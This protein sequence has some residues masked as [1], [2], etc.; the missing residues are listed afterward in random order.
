MSTTF[1]IP[2]AFDNKGNVID[3]KDAV[4]NIDYFCQCGEIVR[5]R[6]GEIISDHFYHIKETECCNESIIHK[7]YKA[8]LLRDKKIKLPMPYNGVSLLEF[9]KV[10]LEKQI[11]DF[12]PDAIGWKDGTRYLI[13]F[14]KTNWIGER[15]LNKIKKS[16]LFCLEVSIINATT[17]EEISNHL[18][19]DGY[20][21]QIIHAPE[22]QEFEEFKNK[23][24]E[25][26]R[27]LRDDYE[28]KLKYY[29]QTDQI[30][31]H[32]QGLIVKF[33]TDCKNG[34]KLYCHN[35]LGLSV[36]VVDEH[37]TI[38]FNN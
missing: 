4:K 11:N 21:K 28:R 23:S 34:A 17:T 5:L 26:F 20:Y 37:L 33:R 24:R 27:K 15:K 35:K 19:N 18:T 6:G 1:K 7:A 14:A 10:E 32:P 9:D 12:Q 38:K 2:F 22:H 25:E 16:N 8:V 29:L 30:F 36:F 13:E 3:Y 31:R